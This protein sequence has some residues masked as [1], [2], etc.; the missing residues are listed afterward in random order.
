MCAIVPAA[1]NCRRPTAGHNNA[2]P[3]AIDWSHGRPFEVPFARL[4][5]ANQEKVVNWKR[6]VLSPDHISSA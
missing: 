2:L 5:H 6:D 4:A 1:N 3:S